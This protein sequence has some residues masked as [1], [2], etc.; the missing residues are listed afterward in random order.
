M[1]H[2]AITKR[3]ELRLRLHEHLLPSKRA[4]I[5]TSLVLSEQDT[6][7]LD[8]ATSFEHQGL[9]SEFRIDGTNIRVL[10]PNC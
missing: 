5:G 10:I 4:S 7:Q 6:N 8:P 3:Q 9:A 1:I 2:A